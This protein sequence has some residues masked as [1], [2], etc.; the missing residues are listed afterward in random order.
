MGAFDARDYAI[1]RFKD[2]REALEQNKLITSL[3]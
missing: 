1:G 2:A 3:K